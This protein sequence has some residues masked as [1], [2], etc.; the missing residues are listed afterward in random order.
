M[1]VR[2][3]DRAPNFYFP[4]SHRQL[5]FSHTCTGRIT[6]GVDRPLRVYAHYGTI[7]WSDRN[8]RA[9]KLR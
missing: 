3:R 8:R 4:R 7:V 9:T 6:A 2:S 1:G 5:P